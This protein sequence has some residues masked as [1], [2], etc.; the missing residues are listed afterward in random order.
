[1]RSERGRIG[2][3]SCLIIVSVAVFMCQEAV[4]A[5]GMLSAAQNGAGNSGRSTRVKTSSNRGVF[6]AARGG[7][8]NSGGTVVKTG[9]PIS[10]GRLP[11]P[12]A[13]IVATKG[14]GTGILSNAQRETTANA[15][16]NSGGAIQSSS[17][18]G[19]MGTALKA[20]TKIKQNLGGSTGRSTSRLNFSTLPRPTVK[21][22]K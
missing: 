2:F 20:A 12:K 16:G 13:R 15:G 14:S 22:R 9:A 17:K 6:E 1:M 7:A 4:W 19:F 18:P 5:K 11:T 10:F 3:L 21:L 8:G